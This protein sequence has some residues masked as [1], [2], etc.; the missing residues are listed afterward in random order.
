MTSNYN[1]NTYM[2]AP[3]KHMSKFFNIRSASNGLL[4][5]PQSRNSGWAVKYFREF[6]IGRFVENFHRLH[7]CNVTQTP[8]NSYSQIII[9]SCIA[10]KTRKYWTVN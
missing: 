4:D 3:D 10:T 5:N 1:H 7:I 6:D 8:G 2:H 9:F